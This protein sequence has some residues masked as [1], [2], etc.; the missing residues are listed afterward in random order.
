MFSLIV[1]DIGLQLSKFVKAMMTAHTE[2]KNAVALANGLFPID[3]D[4][5]QVKSESKID[6]M[7][8]IP[9]ICKTLFPYIISL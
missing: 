5:T 9:Q 6:K 3:I 1:Q 2:C 4:L 8:W 7:F